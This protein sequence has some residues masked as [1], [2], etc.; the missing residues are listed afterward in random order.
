[1]I[2][3][4]GNEEK[5]SRREK[6]KEE[7]GQSEQID[8]HGESIRDSTDTELI[9]TTQYSLDANISAKKKA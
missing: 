8:S 7:K 5:R 4:S 9:S 2:S 1:M 3:F 6:R